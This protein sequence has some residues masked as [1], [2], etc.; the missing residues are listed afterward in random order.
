MTPPP[1]L[2][3]RDALV[4]AVLVLAVLA[5]FSPVLDA[6]FILFDDPH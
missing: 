1:A 6:D 3:R 5:A 2:D 4:A